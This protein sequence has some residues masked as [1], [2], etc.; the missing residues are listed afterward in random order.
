MAND[1]DYLVLSGDKL[2][3]IKG[4]IT[5]IVAICQQTNNNNGASK[6][7]ALQECC[8]IAEGLSHFFC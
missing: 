6:S 3:L 1:S 8:D 4:M 2:E 5:R 7:Q